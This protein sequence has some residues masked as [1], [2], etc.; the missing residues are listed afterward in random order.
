MTIHDDMINLIYNFL[1]NRKEWVATKDSTSLANFSLTGSQRGCV[2]DQVLFSIRVQDMPV[3]SMGKYHII[4]YAY[5]TI[6]LELYY[7]EA[8]S[9][10]S[11]AAECLTNWLSPPNYTT[12]CI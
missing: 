6:L 5:D 12:Q 7:P 8:P 3:P 1:V 9:T 4:K 11:D 10:I 2:W